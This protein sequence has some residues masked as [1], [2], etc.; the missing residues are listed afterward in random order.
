[1]RSIYDYLDY[2]QYIEDVYKE[3]KYG[4]PYFSF[5]VFSDAAGFKSKSFIQHVINGEKNLTDKSI[6]KINK[7]LKLSEKQFTYFKTMVY[8]NQA[9]DRE[10]RNAYWEQLS[11]YN[12]RN[13]LR[14][15]IN[16]QYEYFT[17]W[18]HKSIRE[19]I[20]L[21]DFHENYE[22][23]GNLLSPPVSTRE[24]RQSVELLL[25]LG[26]V[27]RKNKRYFQTDKFLTTGD[28]VQSLAVQNFHHENLHLTG[29][30]IDTKPR[31][32][33]DISTLVVALSD[34]GFVQF[35][36]EIQHFR[37]KLLEI[38]GMDNDLNCVYHVN[39]HLFPTTSK[40]DEI[41]RGNQK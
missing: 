38:A 33:R 23:L 13:P 10:L 37:K 21:I 41:T 22:L 25:K 19:V 9:K 17:K 20:C 2:R 6:E 24:A 4:N 15:L 30:A 34:K 26:L 39:F 18:Y 5:R 1:M 3:K 27:S 7:V 28:E 32:E 31:H 11:S 12:P 40:L 36:E 16:Q 35:K 8:F 29:E 14:L